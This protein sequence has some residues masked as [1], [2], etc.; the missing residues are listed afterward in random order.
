MRL[1][2]C[3]RRSI[4]GQAPKLY[5]VFPGKGSYGNVEL[6]YCISHI[7]KRFIGHYIMESKIWVTHYS[8]GGVRGMDD[9]GYVLQVKGLVRGRW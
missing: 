3:K 5:S 2:Q 9:Q 6:R 1:C 7:R 4:L 8:R